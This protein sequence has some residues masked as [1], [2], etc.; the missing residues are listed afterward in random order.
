ML[1]GEFLTKYMKLKNISFA[2]LSRQSGVPASTIRSMVKRNNERVS[3]DDLIDICK[4]LGGDLNEYVD[5][6]DKAKYLH[7]PEG[8]EIK[9][10]APL[11]RDRF[12]EM[13]A[14][15]SDDEL[16]ELYIFLEFMR[17]KRSHSVGG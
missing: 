10:S 4:V 2:E 9:K 1:L 11:D 14:D 17:W 5:S 8:Q 15:F 13:I 3:I 7:D 16:Y 6:V 12:L